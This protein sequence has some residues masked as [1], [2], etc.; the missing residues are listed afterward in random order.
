MTNMTLL[1]KQ[2]QV[3]PGYLA[4]VLHWVAAHAVQHTGRLLLPSGRILGQADYPSLQ[5][6][7]DRFVIGIR[8]DCKV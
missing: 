8:K 1:D 6:E 3:H 5:F 4:L 7:Q 2:Y